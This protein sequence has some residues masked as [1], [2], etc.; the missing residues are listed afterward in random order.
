M[1]ECSWSPHISKSAKKMN[2][3]YLDLS[4]WNQRK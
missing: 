1:E 3:S 2:R 4:R